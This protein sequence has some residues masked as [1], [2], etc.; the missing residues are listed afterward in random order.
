MGFETM[1]YDS[2]GAIL[3]YSSSNSY[4]DPNY[5]SG[6]SINYM[7]PNQEQ[8]GSTFEERDA[9]GNV[10]SSGSRTV[11]TGTDDGTGTLT[12]AANQKYRK[13]VETFTDAN[14]NSETRTYYFNDDPNDA[15]GTDVNA[16]DAENTGFGD[17]MAGTEVMGATTRELGPNMTLVGETADT[18]NL[19]AAD[20]S[21]LP[22]AFVNAIVGLVRQR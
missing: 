2:T 6:S 1:Y 21:A 9:A 5:G 3:G 17:F 20:L 13:E 4:S 14:G 22:T 12:G 19:S 15:G 11:T 10:T 7:G 18:S 16:T 8:L